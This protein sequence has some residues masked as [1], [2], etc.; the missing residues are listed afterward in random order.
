MP[1]QL[2]TK[3]KTRMSGMISL[4]FI[5]KQLAKLHSLCQRVGT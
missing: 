2:A 4:G 1:D 5:Q 3:T